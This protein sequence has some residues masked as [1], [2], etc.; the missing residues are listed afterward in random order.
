MTRLFGDSSTTQH[1]CLPI[2]RVKETFLWFFYGRHYVIRLVGVP[3]DDKGVFQ[4]VAL[5]SLICG[6]VVCS[7]YDASSFLRDTPGI[8]TIGVAEQT[9]SGRPGQPETR[10]TGSIQA[11]PVLFD[12]PHLINT[13]ININ[14][15][16]TICILINFI[17]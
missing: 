14:I 17:I 4:P 15:Y 13:C 11:G 3:A 9:C 2:F 8:W 1:V 5:N 6:H 16:M 10:K 7:K 12:I